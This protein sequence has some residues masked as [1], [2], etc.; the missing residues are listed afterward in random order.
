[1]L[2]SSAIIPTQLCAMTGQKSQ[3]SKVG[4]Q[5]ADTTGGARMGIFTPQEIDSFRRDLR[6]FAKEGDEEAYRLLKELLCQQKVINAL[7]GSVASRY[8][9]IPCQDRQD[10]VQDALLRGIDEDGLF[11]LWE[12]YGEEADPEIWLRTKLRGKISDYLRGRK[13]HVSLEEMAEL[14]IEVTE[15][16]PPPPLSERDRNR[17]WEAVQQ[18]LN[19]M[20]FQIVWLR[21]NESLSW[22]QVA[23]LLCISEKNVRRRFS[24]ASTQ[25][26]HC[27]IFVHC[28]KQIG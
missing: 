3:Q 4:S 5:R 19:E 15:L 1:M 2:R 17:F 28:C 25:L 11:G 7:E 27:E 13:Q 12:D 21:V 6:R 26:Q 14:G 23:E 9:N 22:Q 10:M 16:S 24:Y 8:P 18:C 20:D